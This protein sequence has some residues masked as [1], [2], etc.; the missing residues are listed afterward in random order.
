MEI[1]KLVRITIIFKKNPDISDA[2]FHEYWAHTHAPLCTEWMK[3]HGIVKHTQYHL[4]KS[5]TDFISE[6]LPGWPTAA[7]DGIEDFYVHKLEDF[8][9]A[10]LDEYYQENLMPDGK[11]YADFASVF[12]VV[13]EDFVVIDDTKVVEQHERDYKIKAAN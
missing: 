3:K 6:R 7:Y 4:H 11:V 5:G 12:I 2:Q 8:A 1:E 10:L 9:D 13:G